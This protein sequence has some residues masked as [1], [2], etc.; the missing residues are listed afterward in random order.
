MYEKSLKAFHTVAVRGGFTAAAAALNIGQPTISSHVRLLEETFGVELF[1][2]RGR[3]IE[4]TPAGKALS[5]IT[6]GLY[7]YEAEALA[8]L[9]NAREFR[10][11]QLRIGAVGPFDA[12]ELL[13]AFR[14][15]HPKVQVSVF[16]GGETEVLETLVEFKTDI[17]VIGY[18]PEDPRFHALFYKRH[19]VMVI[20]HDGHPL[21][22]RN[23]IEL[24]ELEGQ[25][26][27]LRPP[28]STTRQAFERALREKGVSIRPIM[29][30]N[31]REAVREAVARGI[32]MGIVSESEYAPHENLRA[33]KVS[34]A[35]MHT[36][37]YVL[38]LAERRERPIIDEY[39]RVALAAVAEHG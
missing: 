7:H 28:D 23:T 14:H 3:T 19:R 2:R 27:I 5:E 37:A 25:E 10:S 12:I 1:F 33:L 22:N 18:K 29:E 4:L 32:G 20:V 11:G 24:A 6:T 15:K 31:S 16:L 34:D 8:F 17:G 35:E 9:Q 38:C 26:T 30:I 36:H 39:F 13:K 21:A